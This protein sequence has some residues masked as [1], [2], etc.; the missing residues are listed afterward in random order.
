MI[1]PLMIFVGGLLGSAH[2][3]GMCGAFVLT[4]G[5]TQRSWSAN[6]IR[7]LTYS[8]GRVMVYTFGG[9]VVGFAGWKLGRDFP[10][11]VH[12]QAILAMIAGVLLIAEGLFSTGLIRRP[13]TSAGGCA[14]A[15]SFATMLRAPRLG[16]VLAA[17]VLNGLLPCG[18]VY[19]YLALA[20]SAGSVQHGALVMLVFG[21]GTI[22]ALLL[23]GLSGSLMG[24]TFR[25]RLFRLA[26]WCMIA[27][28]G[29]SIYR[30]AAFMQRDTESVRCPLCES[31]ASASSHA[32]D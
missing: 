27:T 20:A 25:R 22:P 10:Y 28:G 17:G 29:L 1:E 30:G 16:S 5:S 31:S 23:T 18:L 8:A 9:A 19:A 7:Q 4:L 14:A 6:A 11:L 32:A 21:A 13:G 26:A 15:N 2:C 3:V 24:V 12:A